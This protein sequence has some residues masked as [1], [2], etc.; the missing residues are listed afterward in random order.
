MKTSQYPWER[1]LDG[2]V[3]WLREHLDFSC[4]PE[5]MV[6]QAR[7]AA[8]DEKKSIA[9]RTVTGGI[10]IQAYPF[11]DKWQPRLRKLEEYRNS[12]VNNKRCEH[13]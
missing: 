5:S 7:K 3:W 1:W 10:L 2:R 4:A 11:D 9:S 8:A 12:P 13:E 6:S